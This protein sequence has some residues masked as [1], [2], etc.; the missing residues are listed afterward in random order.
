MAKYL[1]TNNI[2]LNSLRHCISGAAL[3]RQ[4]KKRFLRKLQVQTL[5]EGYG[6]SEAS[7]T[8]CNPPKGVERLQYRP[9]VTHIEAKICDLNRC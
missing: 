5:V 6:L 9:A 7:A 4:N 2:K 8:H 3:Y 1:S